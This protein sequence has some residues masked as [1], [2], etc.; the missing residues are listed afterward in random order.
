ML[1]PTFPKDMISTPPNLIKIK[2][3]IEVDDYFNTSVVFPFPPLQSSGKIVQD[4]AVFELSLTDNLYYTQLG[5]YGLYYYKQTLLREI[6]WT[7]QKLIKIIRATELFIRIDEFIDSAIKFY[8]EVGYSGYL[9]FEVELDRISEQKLGT[10][11]GQIIKTSMD[12]KVIY[13][14]TISYDSLF[15]NKIEAIY[16]AIKP[17]CWNF[18]WDI[19][20]DE[21]MQC[22][23]RYKR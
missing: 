4:G 1:T 7:E 22:F 8:K 11:P 19:K 10:Y 17:I 16:E 18:D 9:Q 12:D 20:I 14:T 21:M 3:K 23:K 2:Q 6:E 5:S 15:D 13:K